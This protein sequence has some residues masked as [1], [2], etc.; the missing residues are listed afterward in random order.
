VDPTAQV[1][2]RLD[3]W[4][5][6]L[7]YQLKRRSDVFFS[8]YL[9]EALEDELGCRVCPKPAP[10]SQRKETHDRWLSE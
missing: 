6:F 5:H 3:A 8:P 2:D 4:R 7:D 10:K 1:V 9:V